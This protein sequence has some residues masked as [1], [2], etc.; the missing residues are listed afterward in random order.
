MVF[1]AR[2]AIRGEWRATEFEVLG[3]LLSCPSC[4]GASGDKTSCGFP[5]TACVL[6]ELQQP[7]H[8]WPE[9]NRWLGL[10]LR[11]AYIY[12]NP[13]PLPPTILLLTLG[14]NLYH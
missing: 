10:H 2:V 7:K 12:K 3:S 14:Q 13:D 5:S 8:L 4:G 6:R 1:T 11:L 9:R